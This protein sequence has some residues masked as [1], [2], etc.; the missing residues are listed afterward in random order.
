MSWV[1]CVYCA[2]Y[3]IGSL[4]FTAPLQSGQFYMQ[5]TCACFQGWT[6]SVHCISLSSMQYTCLLCT[7]I[8]YSVSLCV[9]RPSRGGAHSD[10][11]QQRFSNAKSISSDQYFGRSSGDS[12]V[13]ALNYYHTREFSRKKNFKGGRE[14][15]LPKI[16]GG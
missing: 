3:Q 14:S 11:A 13:S 1:W 4:K 2:L 5:C 12:S 16:E 7:C 9:C 15:G 8:Q 10:D 6:F